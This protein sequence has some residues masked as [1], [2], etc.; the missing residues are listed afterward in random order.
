M[1]T[2]DIPV[3]FKSKVEE[4]VAGLLEAEE[5]QQRVIMYSKKGENFWNAHNVYIM[6]EIHNSPE[7]H[8]ASFK[9]NQIVWQE[10]WMFASLGDP[11]SKGEFNDLC[12]IR[13]LNEKQKKFLSDAIDEMG[14]GWTEDCKQEHPPEE[15]KCCCGEM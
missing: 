3:R 1:T 12:A 4:Y 8:D 10:I 14:M 15:C 11:V 5:K 2:V 9:W 6:D 7:C 13:G